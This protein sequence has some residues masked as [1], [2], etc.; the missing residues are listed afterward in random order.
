MVDIC[1][2]QGKTF[3]VLLKSQGNRGKG[4]NRAIDE[5]DKRGETDRTSPN[6]D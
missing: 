4:K 1:I 6:P 5:E 2:C 3:F